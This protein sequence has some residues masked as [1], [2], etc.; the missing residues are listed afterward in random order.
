[1]AH[2]R[3]WPRWAPRL[4]WAPWVGGFEQAGAQTAGRAGERTG[5]RVASPPR[6]F[7]EQN[8]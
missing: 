4:P 3:P 8:S 2:M 1:M 6:I 7:H 5:D